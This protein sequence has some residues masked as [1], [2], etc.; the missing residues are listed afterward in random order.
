M[1]GALSLCQRRKA[2]GGLSDLGITNEYEWDGLAEDRIENYLQAKD[3]VIEDMQDKNG[4]DPSDREWIQKVAP[5]AREMLKMLLLRRAIGLVHVLKPIEEQRK[6]MR[7]LKS[8]GAMQSDQWDSYSRA[9]EIC[10]VELRQVAE[11]SQFI[12]PE[13]PPNSVFQMAVRLY[14]SHGLNWPNADPGEKRDLNEYPC[15][16]EMPFGSKVTWKESDGEI[17]DGTSGVVINGVK[18][19]D[20]QVKV[21]FGKV[22][23]VF[24]VDDL[25]KTGG[26]VVE[27]PP[28]PFK[29]GQKVRWTSQ[30]ADIKADEV[31]E[32]VGGNDGKVR[33]RF[34]SGAWSIPKHEL[35][36]PEGKP[37]IPRPERASVASSEI[38]PP[39]VH[40][41][42]K[43]APMAQ[44]QVALARD[45]GEK[46]GISLGHEPPLEGRKDGQESKLVIQ[47]VL[48]GGYGQK[49]NESQQNPFQKL[50]PHDRIVAVVDGSAPPDKRRPVAGDSKAMLD[51]ITKDDNSVTPLIFIIV[52][53]LGPPLR[54][55]V[56]QRVRANCGDQGWQTGTVVK[57]WEGQDRNGMPVPYAI[58]VDSTGGIVVAPRDHDDFVSKAEPRYK[59]GDKV[60]AAR[61]GG[62]K[63]GTVKEVINDKIRTGYRILMTDGSGEEKAPEELY[64]YLRP[65]A[66]FDKGD[67]VLARVGKDYAPGIVEAVYHPK[68]VYAIKLGDGNVVMAPEDADDFVKEMP[69]QRR[70]SASGGSN[71]KSR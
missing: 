11:E 62:Y 28:K 38:G 42:A 6:G 64:Q 19:E 45:K 10:G 48:P 61:D 31:G 68:W 56:G 4:L 29:I 69:G 33:V 41:D 16:K 15:P 54:F 52:R 32:V 35:L 13:A 63:K 22:I 14:H 65:I 47:Q 34:K 1:G 57:V 50:R 24:D 40:P 5:E 8:M 39:Q 44:L 59:V 27:D 23:R 7:Q 30:D 53:L 58:R 51:V 43:E 18:D 71:R 36:T 49:Y 67:K 26:E 60:M 55:K 9:E 17:P 25:N 12:A 2:C 20:D 3:K 37:V 70:K 21:R 46:L 66:R